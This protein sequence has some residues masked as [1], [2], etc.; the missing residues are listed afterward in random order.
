MKIKQ[1]WVRAR[2]KTAKLLKK[3]LDP[4]KYNPSDKVVD[5]WISFN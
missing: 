2:Q 5:Y 4:E 1:K 3:N